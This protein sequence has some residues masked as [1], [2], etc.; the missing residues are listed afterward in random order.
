MI[1]GEITQAY[2]YHNTGRFVKGMGLLLAIDL[3]FVSIL[4]RLKLQWDVDYVLEL[5]L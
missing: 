4:W 2:K 5:I 3:Y 1:A